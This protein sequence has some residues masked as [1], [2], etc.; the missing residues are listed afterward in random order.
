[1]SFLVPYS[2]KNYLKEKD[3]GEAPIMLCQKRR[4]RDKQGYRLTQKYV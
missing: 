2:K 4:I 1:M 3:K